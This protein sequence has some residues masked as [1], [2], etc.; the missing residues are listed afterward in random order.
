MARLWLRMLFSAP[1]L[2]PW[3]RRGGG[4]V[5]MSSLSLS[6]NRRLAALVKSSALVARPAAASASSAAWAAA[7]ASGSSSAEKSGTS[8]SRMDGAGLRRI[9][10]PLVLGNSAS[11]AANGSPS[12]SGAEARRFTRRLRA[13]RAASG[14]AVRMSS[15]SV[16][17]AAAAGAAAFSSSSSDSKRMVP[18]GSDTAGGAVWV[19]PTFKWRGQRIPPGQVQA[20]AGPP[21]RRCQSPASAQSLPCGPARW[22]AVCGGA[23]RT[24]P[25]CPAHA[26]PRTR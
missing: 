20:S 7:R 9:V 2:S 18:V 12:T 22:W 1:G 24:A 26:R 5:S 23:A 8:S 17:F 14:P 25:C 15:G 3:R 11:G 13:V 16:V 21:A 19:R 4:A 6:S 10:W